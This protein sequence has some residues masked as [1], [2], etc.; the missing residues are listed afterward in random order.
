MTTFFSILFII[1]AIN[2][3]LIFFSLSATDQKNKKPASS[4]SENSISDI[5]SIDL[6]SSKYKKA[7]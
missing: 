1:L 6:I 4:V 2:A 5:H 7:V 3:V